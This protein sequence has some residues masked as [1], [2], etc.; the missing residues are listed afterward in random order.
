MPTSGS[1][2]KVSE[3]IVDWPN[4]NTSPGENAS[5]NCFMKHGILILC[6]H[7]YRVH[8][9]SWLHFGFVA[10]NCFKSQHFFGFV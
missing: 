3:W 1:Q 8:V 6:E 9:I 5:A 4:G 2:Y 10:F 7:R